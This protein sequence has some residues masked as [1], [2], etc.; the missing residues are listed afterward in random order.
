MRIY[1]DATFL[2]PGR[3][4]GAEHMVMNLVEGLSAASASR[5]E[6]VVIAS[7]EWPASRDVRFLAPP[8]GPNRFVRA[9]RAMRVIGHSADAVLFTNY[10]TPPLLPPRTRTATVIHDLQYR[11]LPEY[12]RLRKRGW[13]RCAHAFTLRRADAVV[14]ISRFVHDDLLRTYGSRWAGKVAVVWNPVSWARLEARR[15]SAHAPI[16]GPYILAAAAHYPHKNLE[17]LI[18]AFRELLGRGLDGDAK[19]VLA[20]QV[21]SQLHGVAWTPD[22][23]SQIRLLGLEGRVVVTGYVDDARLG[24][25]YRGARLFAFPSL[26]EGFALPPVE[27]LGFGLPVVTTR[28][29]SIP[30]VTLGLARYLDDPLDR[31]AMAGALEEVWHDPEHFRPPRGEI[32]RVRRTFDP[33]VI[34]ARYLDLLV[35]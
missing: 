28:R 11:H 17:T 8:S 4:G 35:G 10:F 1:V 27:A 22:L 5:A 9:T 29:G 15:S 24:E 3:V 30:E 7:H 33:A 13:L 26:F 21:G 12:F 2:V 19:L 16:E 6:I 18:A 34:G 14:A 23:E 32:E 20:G 31:G 25:L